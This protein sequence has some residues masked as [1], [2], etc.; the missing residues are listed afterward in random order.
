MKYFKKDEKRKELFNILLMECLWIHYSGLAW[1]KQ[2]KFNFCLFARNNGSCADL[3]GRNQFRYSS[4][5]TEPHRSGDIP[6][7]T[8]DGKAFPLSRL[9][10]NLKVFLDSQFLL[11]EQVSAVARKT[12]NSI[13]CSSCAIS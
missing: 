3:I 12:F 7:L 1:K 6:A 9:S 2:L 11:E 8:L 5:K 10:C 13:W 4:T